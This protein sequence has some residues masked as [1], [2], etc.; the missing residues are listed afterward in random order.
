M[1]SR[2]ESLA[3]WRAMSEE[4]QKNLW[5]QFGGSWTFEMFSRSTMFIQQ[6]FNKKK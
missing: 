2:Q 5:K 4:E 1:L 3:K 6:A